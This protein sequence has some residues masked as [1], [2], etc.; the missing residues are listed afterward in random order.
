[1]GRC[2]P[3][4]KVQLRVLMYSMMRKVNKTVVY[5]GNLLVK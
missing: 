1:M 4:Y 3:E 2:W 5:N